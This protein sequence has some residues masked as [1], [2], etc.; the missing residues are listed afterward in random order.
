MRQALKTRKLTS[1]NSF[2][3]SSHL[4]ISKTIFFQLNSFIFDDT[5]GLRV[6][7]FSYQSW[8][9][10]AY[11]ENKNTKNQY[12]QNCHNSADINL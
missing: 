9:R 2:T 10:V 11:Q 4:N 5:V 3:A 7:D 6:K 8:L 12:I 1:R